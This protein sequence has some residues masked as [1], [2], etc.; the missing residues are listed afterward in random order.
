MTPQKSKVL[1][2]SEQCRQR[3]EDCTG[4]G[5]QQGAEEFD[6]S[7]NIIGEKRGA[8][9]A[10]VLKLNRVQREFDLSDTDIGDAVAGKIA[11]ALK[12]NQGLAILKI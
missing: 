6:L 9:I 11:E 1:I 2:K 7:E 12:L 3:G 4:A 8:A 10:S 5:R